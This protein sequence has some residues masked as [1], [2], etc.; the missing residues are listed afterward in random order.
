MFSPTILQ[1]QMKNRQQL[2]KTAIEVK[3]VTLRLGMTKA[4]VG[5]KLV[6]QEITKINDDDWMIG[7]VEDLKAGH[8]VRDIQ[9]THGLL[10][11]ADRQWTTA[12]NDTA[13]ALFGVVTSLNDEGF[14][15]CIVTADT[16]AETDLGL[17]SQRVWI[18]CGEKTVLVAR[19][20]IGGKSFSS[21]TEQLGHMRYSTQ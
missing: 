21:V 14:S 8:D 15:K 13:E 5:E 7:T 1:A 11:Y 6:G 2:S 19:Q 12:N 3:G 18:I 9:F 16:H 4:Q 20:T 10:S 17:N